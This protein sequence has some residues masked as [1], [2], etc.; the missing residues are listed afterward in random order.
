MKKLYIIT[1]IISICI[2]CGLV[3]KSKENQNLKSEPK[4]VINKYKNGKKDG[5]WKYYYENGQLKLEENYENGRREGSY[6]SYYKNGHLRWEK[7]LKNNVKNGVYRE[8]YENGYL[9]NEIYYTNN[10][11]DGKLK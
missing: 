7:N 5:K 10:L 9:K 8:G 2:G 6:K 3:K 11:L 1:L 4:E